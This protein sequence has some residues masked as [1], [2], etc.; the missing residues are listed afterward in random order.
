MASR[1][2]SRAGSAGAGTL[3]TQAAGAPACRS[4]RWLRPSRAEWPRERPGLWAPLRS[5]SS[6]GLNDVTHVAPLA[7]CQGHRPP[8]TFTRHSSATWWLC[9]P[10]GQTSGSRGAT[11]D[12]RRQAASGTVCDPK[13]EAEAGRKALNIHGS[14]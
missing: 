1:R 13:A 10:R 3:G 11:R 12:S 8:P 14:P 5:G 9:L 4:E 2:R 6:R 7:H